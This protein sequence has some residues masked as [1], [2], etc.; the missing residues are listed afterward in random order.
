VVDAEGRWR[1][2]VGSH[3][4]H[5]IHPASDYGVPH[6]VVHLRVSEWSM[7]MVARERTGGSLDGDKGAHYL[8]GAEA[9][10]NEGDEE[11]LIL[12]R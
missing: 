7:S 1:A 5:Y 2:L 9:D 10:Q 6:Y 12:G 11:L 3:G 8:E 4:M